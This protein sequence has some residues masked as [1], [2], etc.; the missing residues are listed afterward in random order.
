V[1]LAV[2]N[3]ASEAE[4]RENQSDTSDLANAVRLDRHARGRIFFTHGIGWHHFAGNRW[5]LDDATVQREVAHLLGRAISEEAAEFLVLPGEGARAN[6]DRLLRFLPHAES[7]RGVKAALSLARSSFAVPVD[8]LDALP[9]QLPC[10]N[11]VVDLRT[12]MVRKAR[13]ED[14]VTRVAAVDYNPEARSELWDRVVAR[15]LPDPGTRQHFRRIIGYIACGDPTEDIVPVIHG[16]TA[17]MKGTTL[18]AISAAFGDHASTLGL[19]DLAEREKNPGGARPELVRLR[20]R[21]LA[22]AHETGRR[23][24]LD[25]ALLKSIAGGDKISARALYQAPIEFTPTFTVLIVGN[26]R[27]SISA[28]DDAVWRRILEIPFGAQVPEGE[29]REE[30]RRR[31]RDPKGDLPAVLAWI[32]EGASEYLEHGLGAR[33]APVLEATAEFRDAMDPLA[34]FV[35][36]RCE[37]A[38][39]AWTSAAK[40]TE[41]YLAWCDEA[42]ERAVRGRALGDAL[43]RHG[44]VAERKFKARGWNGIAVAGDGMTE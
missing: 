5:I 28:S 29:R 40:I 24:R 23:L 3:E 1:S 38:R 12:R 33:P 18:G 2:V 19:E 4:E 25:D 10:P 17:S 11:G 42:G 13:P 7:E 37:L 9:R 8:D 20:G 27:P 16:P 30:V 6:A 35:R 44:C 31:L 22:I 41:S 36:D 21:R 39:G 43:R 15:A 32:V 14:R 26:F 34:G